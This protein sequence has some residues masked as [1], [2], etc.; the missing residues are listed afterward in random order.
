L[1]RRLRLILLNFLLLSLPAVMVWAAEPGEKVAD[2]ATMQV[3]VAGLNAINAFFAGWYNSN[4]YVFAILVTVIM[5]V[6]GGLIAFVTD[7][8]LK[9][10]GMDVSKIEHH[11]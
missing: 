9:V 6:V 2:F 8:I 4:K 3:K 11:E 1:V 7:R 10:V 5:G